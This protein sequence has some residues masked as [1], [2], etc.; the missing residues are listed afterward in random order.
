M[1]AAD[2]RASFNTVVEGTSVSG[3]AGV[4]TVGGTAPT[5]KAAAAVRGTM[6]VH[7]SG[8]ATSSFLTQTVPTKTTTIAQQYLYVSAATKPPAIRNLLQIRN[9]TGNAASAQLTSTNYLEVYDAAASKRY[10]SGAAL[11][12]GWYVLTVAVTRGTTTGD[13]RLAMWLRKASDDTLYASL[14]LLTAN[15]GTTDITSV[16]HGKTS[17]TGTDGYYADE[18]AAAWTTFGE[19]DRVPSGNPPI[20]TVQDASGQEPWQPI[21]LSVTIDDPDGGPWTV[22]WQHTAGPAVASFTDPAAPDTILTLAPTTVAD[23]THT[24]TVT[25]TDPTMLTATATVT[26][27]LL[28]ATEYGPVNGVDVPF[29]LL[30]V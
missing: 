5:A 11:P 1:V 8:A 22:L 29:R 24:V 15:T 18:C 26:V 12:D 20:L 3:S 2:K 19:I 30:W 4:D 13:G 28:K 14:D 23:S 9:A 21:P 27:G 16:R 6:G 7:F 10:D 25:V 17:G